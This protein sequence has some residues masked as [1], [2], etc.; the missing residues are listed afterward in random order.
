MIVHQRRHSTNYIQQSLAIGKETTS[1]IFRH[2][3]QHIY[4]NDSTLPQHDTELYG[5]STHLH[6]HPMHHHLQYQQENPSLSPQQSSTSDADETST[7]PPSLNRAVNVTVAA[8]IVKK[9]KQPKKKRKDPNEPQKPVSPYALFFRDTQNDI[10]KKLAN[11]SFGEISKVVA[12]MWENI[13]P[14]VKEQYK[15]KAAAAKKEYL[16]QLAAY[17]AVQVSHQTPNMHHILG[18]N[19]LSFDPNSMQISSSIQHQQKQYNN[20]GIG[21]PMMSDNNNFLPSSHHHHHHHVP[22]YNHHHHHHHQLQQQYCTPPQPQPPPPPPP[23]Q[24]NNYHYINNYS[25]DTSHVY[26]PDSQIHFSNH[27]Q[28]HFD[29][30][31]TYNT[32]DSNNNFGDQQQYGL[33]RPAIE[34]ELYSSYYTQSSNDVEHSNIDQSSMSSI[35]NENLLHNLNTNNPIITT[36]NSSNNTPHYTDLTAMPISATNGIIEK[37]Y[38]FVSTM[39]HGTTTLNDIDRHHNNKEDDQSTLPISNENN[40]HWNQTTCLATQW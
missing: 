29:N 3:M 39:Q 27:Q 23:Q 35:A 38:D 22:S 5:Q 12:H 33:L 37:H 9:K 28:H 17:R 6:Q 24:F 8:K 31:Q 32:Y 7:P 4:A 21:G 20:P 40:F 14:E 11:P 25:Q 26:N 10:K 30:Q 1:R 16:K 18:Q 2:R 34:S 13:E 36:N 19:T 15:R